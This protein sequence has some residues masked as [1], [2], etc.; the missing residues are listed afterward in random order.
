MIERVRE[1]IPFKVNLSNMPFC[2][3]L[4]FKDNKNGESQVYM[5]I[6][7]FVLNPE[8]KVQT[9][10]VDVPFLVKDYMNLRTFVYE[11]MG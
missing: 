1:G 10:M 6:D 8:G 3:K 4:V 9:L 11:W 7:Q 5:K 2:L